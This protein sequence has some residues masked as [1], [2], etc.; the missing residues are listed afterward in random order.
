MLLT[1]PHIKNATVVPLTSGHVTKKIISF[2][3]V[4][5]AG[6]RNINEELKRFLLNYLPSYMIPS[7]FI[8]KEEFPLNSNYKTDKKALLDHYLT[9]I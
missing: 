5:S 9:G 8:V 4:D 7:E 3:I 6:F 1:H 2:V